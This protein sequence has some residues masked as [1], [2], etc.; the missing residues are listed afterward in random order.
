MP[1]IVKELVEA[2]G[3]NVQAYLADGCLH[4][5]LTLPEHPL[6]ENRNQVSDIPQV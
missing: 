6:P 3:G 5:V 4:I 2:H 1:A